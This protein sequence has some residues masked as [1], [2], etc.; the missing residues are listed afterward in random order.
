[1]SMS[2]LNQALVASTL[3][4]LQHLSIYVNPYTGG[5]INKC[6]VSNCIDL[7]L[8][9]KCNLKPV[10]CCYLPPTHSA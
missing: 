1:M 5:G 3:L 8:N 7:C 9:Y 10:T 4:M 2:M 6:M